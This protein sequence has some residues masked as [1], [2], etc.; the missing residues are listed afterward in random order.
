MTEPSDNYAPTEADLDLILEDATGKPVKPA[1]L[2]T[3]IASLRQRITQLE[4]EKT[5]LLNQLDSADQNSTTSLNQ[6]LVALNQHLS[7]ARQRLRDY[8]T[9]LD[10]QN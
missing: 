3:G 9:Q 4:G 2:A 6:Q 10:A 5:K 1:D 8:E 7:S